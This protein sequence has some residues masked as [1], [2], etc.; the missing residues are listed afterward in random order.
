MAHAALSDLNHNHFYYA[1]DLARN[2]LGLAGAEQH[3]SGTKV[4]LKNWTLQLGAHR[5][6]LKAVTNDFSFVLHLSPLKEP[7]LHGEAGYS[8]KGRTPERASCYYSFT[9]LDTKGQLRV[10]QTEHAVQG[11]SWMDHEFSTAH[12]EPGLTGWDW[13]SLQL[14]DRTEV[15]IYLLR[16]TDG[17]HSPASSGTF[18][19][20]SG[21]SRH[22]QLEEFKVQILD[23]WQSPHSRATYPSRWR[24][25]ILPLA[26]EVTVAPNLADQ[27]IQARKGAEIT[28]WE[29][30]VSVQGN[31]R[32]AP[33]SGTGYV[34]LT[35][36]AKALDAPM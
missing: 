11:L 24:L 22:L 7:V 4:F 20:A 29:G 28:Y 3:S 13:F 12:L 19:D 36:Y 33:V 21:I 30:S 27:E 17:S 14:S 23:T 8:R 15:M 10:G 35:G 25:K 32:G 1:E 2:A 31:A 6:V 18:I 34:E 9:R 5:H 16:H 26:L